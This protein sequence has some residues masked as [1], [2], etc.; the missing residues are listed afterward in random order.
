MGIKSYNDDEVKFSALKKDLKDLPKI[1]TPD[2]FE[3]NLFTKIQ[4]KSFETVTEER[5]KFNLIKFFAPSAIVVTAIVV[6]FIFLPNADTQM[7][8]PLMSEPQAITNDNKQLSEV[9][10]DGE[11][12]S[13]EVLVAQDQI[14]NPSNNQSNNR[15]FI[16]ISPQNQSSRYPINRNRSVA[17]D[18]FISGDNNNRSNIRQGNV[19]NS[20]TGSDEFDG[21]FVREQPDKKTIEKYRAMIDSVKKVQAKQDSLKKA[22]KTK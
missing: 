7:D 1:E 22:Q 17:I 11:V 9:L 21:F 14:P 15:G 10:P 2:N 16:P 8:N 6:F 19:V 5:V 3:Y 13:N 4:N 18:D 20:G 12:T